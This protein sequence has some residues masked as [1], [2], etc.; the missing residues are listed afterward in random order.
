M[1]ASSFV[2][3]VEVAIARWLCRCDG[4]QEGCERV[5]IGGVGTDQR[6]TFLETVIKESLLFSSLRIEEKNALHTEIGVQITPELCGTY[7]VPTP[8]LGWL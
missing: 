1:T 4:L 2:E 5:E 6:S 3:P 8:V 7:P